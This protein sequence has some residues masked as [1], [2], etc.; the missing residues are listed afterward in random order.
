MIDCIAWGTPDAAKI[1]EG[2]NYSVGSL[3]DLEHGE[4]EENGT[5]EEIK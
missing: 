5:V 2:A 3:N 4:N 1:I